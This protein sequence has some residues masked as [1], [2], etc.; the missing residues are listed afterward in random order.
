MESVSILLHR[1]PVEI[2]TSQWQ[3]SDPQICYPELILLVESFP[4]GHLAQKRGAKTGC[5][6]GQCNV[7]CC[8]VPAAP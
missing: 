7:L 8:V 6:L 3:V 5:D 2:Q 4:V 1:P